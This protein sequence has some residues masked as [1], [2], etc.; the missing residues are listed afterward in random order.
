MASRRTPHIDVR[1]HYRGSNHQEATVEQLA[2]LGAFLEETRP[3]L[4]FPAKT[5]EEYFAL[6]HYILNDAE[7]MPAKKILEQII[8]INLGLAI[9]LTQDICASH[10]HMLHIKGIDQNDVLSIAIM[11]K[12]TQRRNKAARKDG[13]QDFGRSDHGL[14]N[15]ILQYDSQK[16]A[17]FSTFVTLIVTRAI[18]R[19]INEKPQLIARPFS[20]ALGNEA[21]WMQNATSH[22]GYTQ[23]PADSKTMAMDAA[24][25]LM[26]AHLLSDENTL[27]AAHEKD[28]LRSYT[29]LHSVLDRPP[30]DTEI[31]EDLG[32]T[33]QAIRKTFDRI[34]KKIGD[35]E[36]L[37]SAAG[38][39]APA[40]S[41][42][43]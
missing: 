7:A 17:A 22:T 41:W 27:L 29:K 42:K 23:Q 37:L 30:T 10:Q 13:L 2:K 14:I 9:T 32:K 26:L 15:A 21:G 19:Y 25:V 24:S 5:A 20:S 39:H 16:D 43:R 6:R 38:A 1:P 40:A 4:A 12:P 8:D 18:E 3:D 35:S 36:S 34:Q 31:G 11:G 28:V 33:R